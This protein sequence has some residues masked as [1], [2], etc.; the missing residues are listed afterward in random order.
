[1]SRK[2]GKGPRGLHERL[3]RAALEQ[4]ARMLE[5]EAPDLLDGWGETFVEEHRPPAVFARRR[6]GFLLQRLG[7]RPSE[8]TILRVHCLVCADMHRGSRKA[9]ASKPIRCELFVRDARLERIARAHLEPLV[10][11]YRCPGF[12]IID[13][14]HKPEALPPNA[15]PE[16]PPARLL[17]S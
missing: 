2:K 9:D 4:I 11:T 17:T 14:S 10:A 15:V 7:L 16:L 12:E 3:M 5:Q 1:M 6:P 8:R 13:A